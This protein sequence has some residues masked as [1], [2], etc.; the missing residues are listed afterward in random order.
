VD[1]LSM[2]IPPERV[3]KAWPWLEKVHRE[4]R[5]RFLGVLNFDLLGHKVCCDVFREFLAEVTIP[6]AVHAM[7]VHPLNTNEEMASCCRGLGIQVL[8]Y[9]PL[10]APHKVEAFMRALTRSDAKDM[11]PLLKLSESAVLKD[12]GERH[13]VSSAQVALRWNLQR[14]HCV[15]PK[16][17]VEEHIA[18]NSQLFH[19]ALSSKEMAILSGLHKGLRAERFL[20]QALVQGPKALPRMT[21]EAQDTCEAILAK[22]RGPG[23]S[24]TPGDE[25]QIQEELAELYRQ[26][27]VLKGRG[28]G[29]EVPVFKEAG[30]NG[31]LGSPAMVQAVKAS[32]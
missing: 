19:F 5:A 1:L 30:Q 18:E 21:R 15:V 7:E 2:D 13:G 16:S 10:A 20:Q 14:G 17:F 27:E 8:A 31:G 22:F 6:P 3:P 29:F 9:S 28:K 12:I 32:R 23:Q 25:Q 24:G 4:G 26:Q 11:R